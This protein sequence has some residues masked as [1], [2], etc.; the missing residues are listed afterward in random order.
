MVFL[1]FHRTKAE[2]HSANIF[3]RPKIWKVE[4]G[5]VIMDYNLHKEIPRLNLFIRRYNINGERAFQVSQV[6]SVLYITASNIKALPGQ[7]DSLYVPEFAVGKLYIGDTFMQTACMCAAKS[8][9]NMWW[10]ERG[11]RISEILMSIIITGD[12]KHIRDLR[13]RAC[14]TGSH[15]KTHFGKAAQ[16][17]HSSGIKNS[18]KHVWHASC[19][20]LRGQLNEISDNLRECF[21][22]VIIPV[23]W[24]T[25]SLQLM[26]KNEKTW[27]H[28][29]FHLAHW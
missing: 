1:Y 15:F 10:R 26:R 4:G 12:G 24:I 17:R 19:E 18:L 22:F 27:F 29:V 11:G 6:L 21:V 23:Y 2:S 8:I 5:K 7:T 14:K 9:N 16:A 3:K 25:L 13:Q 20:E 28:A